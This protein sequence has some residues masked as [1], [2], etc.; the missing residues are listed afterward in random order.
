MKFYLISAIVALVLAMPLAGQQASSSNPATTHKLTI[1]DKGHIRVAFIIT[2]DAVVIDFAGPWEVFQDVHIPSRGPNMMDQM[3]FDPYV[4]SDTKNPV[5]ASDGMT[6]VPD[7]T[8]DDAPMPG[9]VVVPAQSPGSPKMMEWIRKMSKESDVVMSVCNGA[10]Q[11]GEAGVLN[12]KKATAHHSAYAQFQKK[13]PEVTLVRGMRYVQSDP[14]IFTAGGLSSG[15]DLAL[16]IVDLY[17]GRDTAVATAR[18]MEYEG[19][20]WMGDGRATVDFSKHPTKSYPS[21]RLTGG[22]LGNWH[23]TLQSADGDFHVALHVWKDK[24]GTLTGAADSVDEENY[25]M[26]LSNVTYQ[27]GELHFDI[28]SVSGTYDGKVN[29]ADTVID[30]TWKQRGNLVPLMLKRK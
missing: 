17:F 2:E 9:I 11:L 12:G 20:G 10:F 16:H 6:I 25:G 7:Y 8:F 18:A 19:K 27:G 15:I 29:A 26:T 14:I 1:P 22:A 23:G 21:D 13:F 3:I 28:E 5:H 4:V 24:A 30:G